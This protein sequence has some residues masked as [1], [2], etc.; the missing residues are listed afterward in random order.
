IPTDAFVNFAPAS[1]ANVQVG[2]FYLPFTLENRI[3]DNTMPFLE[4]SLVV[5][6]LGAPNT[7]DV[8]AMFWG[9]A[10]DGAIYY[11]AGIFDG[12]GPNRTNADNRFDFAGHAFVRPFVHD[13]DGI[14]ENLQV[15]LSARYGSRDKN[16]VGYDMPNLTTQA[17][18]A[19]W[20]PTYKD[21][22][23]RTLH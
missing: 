13:G 15:G 19:Y 3:S 21:S 17:G 22:L 7:R 11:A 23:G 16:L 20:K 8:G 9:E 1:W 18:F 6:N 4:R 2:Q 14:G 12:D 10:L 5:R